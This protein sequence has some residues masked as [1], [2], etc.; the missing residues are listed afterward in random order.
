MQVSNVDMIVRRSLLEKRL[1]IHWYAEFLF[2]ATASIRELS[3]DTLKLINFINLPI[4][5]TGNAYLPSDF[6][7]DIAVC[8]PSGQALSH[9][10]KQDWITPIRQHDSVT[11]DFVA[12]ENDNNGQTFFGFPLMSTFWFWNV[13]DFGEPS[14]R[15]FG[16]NGGT[17]TGYS[18]FKQQRRIQFTQDLLSTNAV[19]IY[20]GNGQSVDNATQVEWMAFRCIQTYIDWQRSPNATVKD[21]AEARTYYN[22]KRLLRANLNSLTIVDIK[23]IIHSNYIAAIKS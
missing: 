16:S 20:V 22:E 14:G 13:N 23:N 3:K 2:H 10:P 11:G 18:I 4:D 7:D 1:P 6:V 12:Y 21:S 17:T 8:L 15:F 9:I 5:A 19:L